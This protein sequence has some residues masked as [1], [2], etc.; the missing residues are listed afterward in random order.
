MNNNEKALARN[1]FQNKIYKADGQAFEKS[2]RNR[3]YKN[4][5]TT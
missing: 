2:Y 5:D 4:S 3:R 1:L